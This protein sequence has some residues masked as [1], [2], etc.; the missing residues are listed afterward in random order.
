MDSTKFFEVI[1]DRG[2]WAASYAKELDY[3]MLN[4]PSALETAK[5][6]ARHCRGE[7]VKVDYENQRE[8]IWPVV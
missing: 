7:V 5:I 8:V 6:T 3:K 1:D 2:R 4:Q